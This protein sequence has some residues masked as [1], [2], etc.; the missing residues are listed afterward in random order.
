MDAS[1]DDIQNT[2]QGL[3]WGSWDVMW[4]QSVV[5][6]TQPGTIGGFHALNT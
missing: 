6:L 5:M 3:I 4:K 2:A 1:N